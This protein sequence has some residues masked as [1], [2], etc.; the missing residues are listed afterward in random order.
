M[1]MGRGMLDSLIPVFSIILG[2]MLGLFT[3]ILLSRQNQKQNITEK[4]LDQYLKAREDICLT[5]SELADLKPT[6]ITGTNIQVFKRQ[7]SKIYHKYYDLLPSEALQEINCLY[8]CLA[9]KN[10]RLFGIKN[11]KLVVLNDED[12]VSVLERVSLLENYK[13]AVYISLKSKDLKKR[14]AIS[15]N[16]QARSVLYTLNKYFTIKSFTTWTKHLSKASKDT[17]H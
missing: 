4:V 2:T 15:I 16:V 14:R 1:L 13:H 11:K 6:D 5:L 9:D 12:I 8:I 3:S 10:N 7:V 17:H